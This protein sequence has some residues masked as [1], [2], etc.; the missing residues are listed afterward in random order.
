ML[1][2]VLTLINRPL[3]R[4]RAVGDKLAFAGP[5]LAR[6]TVGLVFIGTGWGKL[7]NLPDVTEF[8]ASLHIPAPGFNARLSSWACQF[9]VCKMTAPTLSPAP[10]HRCSMPD[11]F[12]AAASFPPFAKHCSLVVLVLPWPLQPFCPA[13]A[14]VAPLQALVPLQALIPSH[15]TSSPLLAEATP[16]APIAKRPATDAA[17]IAPLMLMSVSYGSG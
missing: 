6:L 14:W 2:F 1:T 7:H 5:M 9:P 16:D 13:Q 17:I 8:F 4:L 12:S 3:A 15:I 10:P 11:Y